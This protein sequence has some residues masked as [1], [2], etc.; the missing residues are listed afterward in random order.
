[1][2]FWQGDGGNLSSF[3]TASGA[4][5]AFERGMVIVAFQPGAFSSARSLC[6]SLAPGFSWLVN[7]S[8]SAGL[9]FPLEFRRQG[10]GAG[11]KCLGIGSSDTLAPAMAHG[12]DDKVPSD[13]VVRRHGRGQVGRVG[14]G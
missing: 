12:L 11:K 10:C 8:V 13:L 2:V 3:T 4:A 5:Q 1:M 6:L 14:R 9:R 7:P